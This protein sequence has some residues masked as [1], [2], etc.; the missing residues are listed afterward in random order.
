[1]K[2][3]TP[4]NIT[5]L[6]PGEIFVFG[7]NADGHHCG[8]AA[9]LAARKFGAQPGCGEGPQGRC[10][11]IPTIGQDYER[12]PLEQIGEA[13]ARF[14]AFAAKNPGFTFLV[15]KIGCGIAGYSTREIAPL[16]PRS[17]PSNIILPTEFSHE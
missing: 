13:I 2:R 7:S 3:F 14:V 16:W 17:L 12:M 8:G 10:Y 5:H 11:A 6:E 1:M 9:L 4:E 15:T